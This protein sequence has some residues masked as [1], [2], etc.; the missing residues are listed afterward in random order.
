MTLF[1]YFDCESDAGA[2][3]KAT[4]LS[5]SA[6]TVD[7]N[8]KTIQSWTLNSRFRKS[9]AFEV[10]AMLAHNI[11]VKTIQS[12]ILSNGELIDEWEKRFKKLAERGTIF[13]GYNSQNYDNILLQNSLFVNLKFPYITNKEQ[14]DLLPAIRAAN[15]FAPGA[16]N[17][18]LNSKKNCWII[19]DEIYEY[20]NFSNLKHQSFGSVKDLAKK[21]I[22]I[23]G[24][25]KAYS[26]TGWRIGY[27]H[28]P[29]KIMDK[30][31]K[32]Q[33]HINTNVPVFTQ[34]AAIIPSMIQSRQRTLR[35]CYLKKLQRSLMHQLL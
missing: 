8:F 22:T 2:A 19:S 33:Q 35:N 20:L 16:L 23:N 15:V 5:I 9:R 24:F 25:S 17:Y 4:C 31:V 30:V 11:P 12:E 1:T 26:M 13:V 3:Q 21:T 10:D 27:M 14:F 28:A 29:K 32:I 6:V 7:E 34:K 18:E